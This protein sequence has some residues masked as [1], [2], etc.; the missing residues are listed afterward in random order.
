MTDFYEQTKDSPA[1]D[2]AVPPNSD[3]ISQS[4]VDFLQVLRTVLPALHET[5]LPKVLYNS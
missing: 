1:G 3:P 4:I 5:L 2:I